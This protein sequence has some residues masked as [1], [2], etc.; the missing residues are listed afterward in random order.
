MTLKSALKVL[1][2]TKYMIVSHTKGHS[3]YNWIW[4]DYVGMSGDQLLKAIVERDKIE[5]K[6]NRVMFINYNSAYKMIEV[7]VEVAA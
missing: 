7:D 4:F 6:N 2:D 3:D 5:A 1:C